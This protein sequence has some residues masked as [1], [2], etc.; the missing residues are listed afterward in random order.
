[1]DNT[2]QYRTALVLQGGGALGA[3]E[4]GVLKALYKSRP[5]F[6]PAVVTGIS[7]GAITAAVLVGAREDP[8]QTLEELWRHKFTS[9]HSLP[10]FVRGLSE[11]LIPPE[12]QKYLALWGNTGMY[13]LRPEYCW[14]PLHA[15]SVYELTPLRETLEEMVDIEKLNQYWDTRVMV[16]AVN[17]ATAELTSFDNRTGLTLEHIVASASLPPSF[18]MT[19]IG[20]QYYWDGGL[21]SNTPLSM[22]L[23]CLEE[24][25][26]APAVR[27][28][29]IVVE[30]FPRHAKV[31]ST[32][33]EVLN[34]SAQLYFTS[35]LALDEK[36][37]AKIN[38]FI[39]LIQKID[40]VIPPEDQEIRAHPGYAELLRHKKIDA[41]TVVSSHLPL[42]QANAGDFS[43]AT[44]AYRIEAGYR[45]AIAQNIAKPTPVP[46]AP[47]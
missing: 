31:P 11:Q 20:G 33:E 6:H 21:F 1:M 9:L 26:D 39:E 7:I 47:L 25:Q 41:L 40:R 12:V 27:R 19:A 13:A 10:P 23:N 15:T 18:P 8:I 14:A 38:R 42:E 17:I 44:L 34:R 3:Y 2:A 46:S 30:L 36:L 37:F 32:M 45:D 5:Q 29:V 24:I 16:G 43:N 22:A 28:E 35:K 4:Y